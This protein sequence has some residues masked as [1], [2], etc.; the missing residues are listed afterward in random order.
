MIVQIEVIRG[1][2]HL[3]QNMKDCPHNQ[4]TYLAYTTIV[5][6]VRL[7]R[8][9]RSFDGE[10]IWTVEQFAHVSDNSIRES[11]IVESGDGESGGKA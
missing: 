4:V 2:L 5:V 1:H 10:L 11:R 3:R 9:R 8:R 6:R 7:D